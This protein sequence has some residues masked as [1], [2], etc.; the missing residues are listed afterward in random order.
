MLVNSIMCKVICD[1][2]MSD[3]RLKSGR[4]QKPEAERTTP[5]S[6][7]HT[8]VLHGMSSW[9]SHANQ[10]RT[11][12]STTW[13]VFMGMHSHCS[14]LLLKNLLHWRHEMEQIA[15]FIPGQQESFGMM[16]TKLLS[17]IVLLYFS[18]CTSEIYLVHWQNV[19]KSYLKDR[20]LNVKYC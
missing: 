10:L 2:T 7:R 6:Y 1:Y 4:L 12:G 9:E 14:C 19:K 5:S 17:K 16:K 15:I 3:G 13:C 20:L 8:V 18:V 11:H